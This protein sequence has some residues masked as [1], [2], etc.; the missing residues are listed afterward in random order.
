MRRLMTFF[1]G[2]V[3]GGA[4]LYGSLNFH[5]IRAN[6]GVHLVPKIEPKIAA[7]YVDI[8][9]FTFADWKQHTE[10]AAALVR[11]EKSDLLQNT[12]SDALQ[13]GL[14]KW[15]DSGEKQK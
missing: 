5:V 7:T 2:M 1:L 11:A 6:D 12:A 9:N 15:L 13:Q 14:D 8:R 10:I 3:T 4:L